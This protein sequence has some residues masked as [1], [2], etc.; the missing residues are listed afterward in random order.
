MI[1]VVAPTVMLRREAFGS[2]WRRYAAF[3]F[4]VIASHAVLDAFTN[5]GVGVAF[6]AP[7]DGTRYLFPWRP[8][9]VAPVGIRS[10]LNSRVFSVLG[11]EFLWVWLPTIAALIVILVVKRFKSTNPPGRAGG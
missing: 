8:I 9:R 6:F 3:F 10:S 4:V 1:A 11:S 2:T 7:F 5:G